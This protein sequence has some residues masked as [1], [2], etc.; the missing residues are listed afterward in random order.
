MIFA[1]IL[2][3]VVIGAGV[4]YFKNQ[5][6]VNAQVQAAEAQAKGIEAQAQAKAAEVQSDVK[7]DV[8]TVKAAADTIAKQ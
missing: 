5:A 1:I 6:K 7:A 2:L 4:Y 8:A 3:L